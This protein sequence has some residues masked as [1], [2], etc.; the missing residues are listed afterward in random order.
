M[1]WNAKYYGLP[2]WQWALILSAAGYLG[3]KYVLQPKLAPP[4]P[5]PP[6]FSST[7]SQPSSVSV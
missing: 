5:A 3:W 1:N 7:G 4:A 2:L 6:A